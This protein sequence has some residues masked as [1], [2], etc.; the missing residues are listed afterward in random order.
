[1]EQERFAQARTLTLALSQ[2]ERGHAS[3]SSSVTTEWRVQPTREHAIRAPVA[4]K[5]AGVA[6]AQPMR[7]EPEGC[8]LGKP[9]LS[10]A[11]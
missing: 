9:F 6:G 4:A 8:P 11:A 5:Y 2:W 1:V 3:P 10:L 7:G